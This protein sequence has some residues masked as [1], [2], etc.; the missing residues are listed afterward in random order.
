MS[1]TDAIAWTVTVLLFLTSLLFVEAL[2][3]VFAISL[4]RDGRKPKYKHMDKSAPWKT[5]RNH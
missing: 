4:T 1:L 5:S 3:N 2:I